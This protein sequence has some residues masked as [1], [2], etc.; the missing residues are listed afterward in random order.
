[1]EAQAKE[2]GSKGIALLHTCG[3]EDNGLTSIK[4]GGGAVTHE[5]PGGQFRELVLGPLKK[6]GAIAAIEGVTDIERE[7]HCTSIGRELRNL[8]VPTMN[9]SLDSI[10]D[11][12]SELEG[13]EQGGGFA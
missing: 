12:N 10:G 1:M 6:G 11:T 5:D 3:R 2:K 7:E 13:G 4:V 9:K 8:P